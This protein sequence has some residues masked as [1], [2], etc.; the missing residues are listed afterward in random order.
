MHSRFLDMTA[1]RSESGSAFDRNDFLAAAREHARAEWAALRERHRNGESG[2]DVVHALAAAADGLLAGAYRFALRASPHRRALESRTALCALGSYG[3]G[4]LSPN[5]DID[6]CLLHVGPFDADV[7]ALNAFLVPFLWDLG[8]TVGYAVRSVRETC[9]LTREDVKAYTSVWQARL[10]AG[11]P[12]VYANLK[13]CIRETHPSAS[14]RAAIETLVL[15]RTAGLAAPH[16]DL[17]NPTPN[18]KE[19]K[20]GLRDFHVGLW[21]YMLAYGAHSLDDVQAQ[22]LIAPED[23]L[24]LA[25]ALDFVWRIRN[26]LHFH[27]GKAD[28]VLTFQNQRHVA[29]AFGYGAGEPHIARFM[30]DYFSA[31][32]RLRRF[33][34]DAAEAWTG[35]IDPAPPAAP[36]DAIPA[37][38]FHNGELHAGLDDGR[39]FAENPARLMEVFWLCVQ[40][41]LVLSPATERQV[42]ANLGLVNDAFRTNSLVRRYFTAIC[43][44]PL[45]AGRVLRQMMRSGL[46]YAYLPE[47]EAVRGVIR[48]EDF[49]HYPVDEHTIRAVEAL[50][51]LAQAADPAGRCLYICLEHLSD[52]HIL[53]MA[54]LFHDLGKAAGDVHSE[55]SERLVWV[56]A[57]RIG[58]REEDAERVAFLVRRHIA[59]THISQY[60]DI[61]DDETVRA[62]AEEMQTEQRLRELFVLSYADLHA[63]GPN[64]WNEWKGAL[65]MKLYLRAERVLLGRADVQDARFTRGAKAAAVRARMPEARDG[66]LDADLEALGDRYF[67]AFSADQ[68]AV[69]LEC[70]RT[71]RDTGYAVHWNTLEGE[72]RTEVVV[73]ARD[74]M[75]RFLQM[76]GC[77]AAQLIDVS[78]AA[79]FTAPGGWVLDSFTL[80]EARRGRPLTQSEIDALER[81][82]RAVL[83]EEEEVDALVERARRRLFALLQPPFPVATR[84]AFDN[85]SS[86]R[87]TVIDIETGDRTGLLYD[88]ARAMTRAGL[89][90]ANA[91]IVTDARRARDAFYVSRDN[92]KLESDEEKAAVREALLHAIHPRAAVEA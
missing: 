58:L 82:F 33:F 59:M 61:D 89:D 34:R 83:L 60:R 41:G 69:H 29:A 3:R 43:G 30:A 74:R 5:S 55:E 10:I 35:A 70:L 47:F 17:H 44:R 92:R 39:W 37:V 36:G 18:V 66:A 42:A 26:E 62:F 90:I 45:D 7:E 32:Q 50:A 56:I 64:V 79:L 80:A 23:A 15:Q 12:A 21:L 72:G 75:G 48:Y 1:G 51:L 46:L 22:G 85:G 11:S 54:I 19:S 84:I 31:A 53:V 16:D 63:V 77:F 4:E 73:C 68:I 76:A 49:H 65:L 27:G 87:Y 91:R 28:D 81:L 6:V 67:M 38:R 57:R 2:A 88:I 40:K 71:A 86:R 8:F 24:A 14:I 78:G 9:D 25:E 52:T 13:L 20:G